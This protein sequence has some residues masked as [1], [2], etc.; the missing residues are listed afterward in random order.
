LAY[1]YTDILLLT[2]GNIRK[3]IGLYVSAGIPQETIDVFR[4]SKARVSRSTAILPD[5]NLLCETDV[6]V[7]DVLC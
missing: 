5:N 7:A 6:F 3:S 2:H 4:E 1:C